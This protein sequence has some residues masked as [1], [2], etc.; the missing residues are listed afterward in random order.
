M[1]AL[2]L[3]LISSQVDLAPQLEKGPLVLV[4][5][6]KGGKFGQATGFILVNATPDETWALITKFEAYKAF[7]PKVT[8][9]EIKRRTEKDVDLHVTIE[10]PGP[11]TDYVVRYTPDATAKE[12]VGTWVS[13]DLK[14]S[15]WFWKVESAPGNKTL[16][17][18]TLSV[19]NFSGIAQAVEDDSQTVTVGVNVGSVLAALKAVKRKAEAGPEAPAA[20]GTR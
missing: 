7:L 9:S 6:A 3:S 18:H 8:E 10:V 17:T 2:V 1:L 5:E 15:R 14:G 13:G 4:E 11:D 16:L 19:K 20:A 12:I